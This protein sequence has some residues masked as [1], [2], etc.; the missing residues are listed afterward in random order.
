MDF[1]GRLVQT[2]RRVVAVVEVEVLAMV[3]AARVPGRQAGFRVA[4]I[5]VV[6][7]QVP[8]KMW[9]AVEQDTPETTPTETQPNR[10]GEVGGRDFSLLVIPLMA[11]A[12]FFQVAVVAVVVG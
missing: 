1:L 11:V 4:H 2:L 3:A 6:V 5:L 9:E 12:P 8:T 7:Q 10:V